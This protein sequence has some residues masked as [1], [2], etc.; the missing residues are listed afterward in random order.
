M[1]QSTLR[2]MLIPLGVL[3]ALVVVASGCGGGGPKIAYLLPENET[4]RYEA[5]DRPEF[6]ETSN[7]SAKTAKSSTTTQ[8]RTPPSSRARPKRR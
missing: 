2:R 6:E 8:P 4:P 1:S 5:H 7:S 3:I